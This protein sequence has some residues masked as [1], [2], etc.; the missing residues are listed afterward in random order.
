MS[1]DCYGLPVVLLVTQI[2]VTF[3][4]QKQSRGQFILTHSSRTYH[5]GREGMWAI[6][7]CRLHC[8]DSQEA[9]DNVLIQFGT[10]IGWFCPHLEWVFL[11][12]T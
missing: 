1:A 10:P 8:V 11:P 9:E 12:Q 3:L 4:D 7:G 2:L 6:G 5:G